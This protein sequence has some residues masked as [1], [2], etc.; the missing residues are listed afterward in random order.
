MNRRLPTT[1][2]RH[3]PLLRAAIAKARAHGITEFFVLHESDCDHKLR[4]GF[5][6]CNPTI[7]AAAPV[8]ESMH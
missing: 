7:T 2:H 5:C 8:A 1:Q 4:V 3:V 6:N